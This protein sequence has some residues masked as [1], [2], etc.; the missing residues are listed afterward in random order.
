MLLDIQRRGIKRERERGEREKDE[1]EEREREIER[2]RE[3]K[4]TNYV[5]LYIEGMTSCIV[6]SNCYI[7]S[8]TSS[9]LL[10]HMPNIK[11]ST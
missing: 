6:L 3:G 1:R 2:E 8:A 11:L 7:L 4:M 5:T 10:E 9:Y